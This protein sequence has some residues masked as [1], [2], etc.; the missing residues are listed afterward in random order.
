MSLHQL[1]A[2]ARWKFGKRPVWLKYISLQ[3]ATLLCEITKAEF[4]L[5]DAGKALACSP[6]LRCYGDKSVIEPLGV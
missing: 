4:G 3:F 1:V 5:R 6:V 2:N